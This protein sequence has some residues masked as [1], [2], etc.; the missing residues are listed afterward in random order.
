MRLSRSLALVMTMAPLLAGAAV[1]GPRDDLVK[2]V[3]TIKN[4]M[5]TGVN[6]RDFSGL[7][8]ELRTNSDLTAM[9]KSLD[10]RSQQAVTSLS[11]TMVNALD[12]WQSQFGVDCIGSV[13]K[14]VHDLIVFTDENALMP[15]QPAKCRASV[16]RHLARLGYT[17][18]EAAASTEKFT[19]MNILVSLALAK[20]GQ[21]SEAAAA[22]LSGRK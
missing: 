16:I 8:A 14:H 3:V 15:G 22:A 13:H 21:R 7:L 12:S 17:E 9:T 5:A 11:D 19:Y 10:R 2:S 1:A 18:A 4:K 20:V 6:Q